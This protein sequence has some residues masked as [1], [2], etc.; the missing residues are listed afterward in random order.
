MTP[1][2]VSANC[3]TLRISIINSECN[4]ERLIDAGPHLPMLS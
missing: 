1:Y 4:S 2:Q 3:F